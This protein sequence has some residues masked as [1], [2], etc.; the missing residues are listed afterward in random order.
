MRP[1]K[2]ETATR[3]ALSSKPLRGAPVARSSVPMSA[4]DTAATM[5]E[6]RAAG[7]G[8]KRAGASR[9]SKDRGART[10][11]Q[12]MRRSGAGSHRGTRRATGAMHRG[13][14]RARWSRRACGPYPPSARRGTSRQHQEEKGIMK[15]LDLRRPDSANSHSQPGSAWRQARHR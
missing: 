15:K 11:S 7:A 5:P 4:R 1:K 14:D 9:D 13:L 8:T 10:G 3:W 6:T 12:G 2:H